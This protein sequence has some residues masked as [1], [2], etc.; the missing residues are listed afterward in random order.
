MSNQP[1]P[2]DYAIP[3]QGAPTNVAAILLSW[4]SISVGGINTLLLLPAQ[5]APAFSVPIHLG[6]AYALTSPL[7]LGIACW[8]RFGRPR[9]GFAILGVVLNLPLTVWLLQML[10]EIAISAF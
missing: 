4:A 9:V 8:A 3:R 7:W 1:Q 6:V 10:F 5:V 2:L